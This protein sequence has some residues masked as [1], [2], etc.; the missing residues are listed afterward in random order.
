MRK[1]KEKDQNEE[2][3]Q[4]EK[5]KLGKQSKKK[6][7]KSMERE[8]LVQMVHHYWYKSNECVFS[9]LISNDQL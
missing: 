6:M 7:Q 2:E 1:L 8:I 4:Q 9:T 5:T 3:F